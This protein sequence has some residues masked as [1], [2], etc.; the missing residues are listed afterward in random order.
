MEASRGFV[1]EVGDF[2]EEAGFEV[3]R[4]VK[5]KEAQ[6][7]ASRAMKDFV[8]NA[9]VD[10]SIQFG[11]NPAVEIKAVTYEELVGDVVYARRIEKG[12]RYMRKE[13]EK[14]LVERL[15]KEQRSA[16]SIPGF[17][18]VYDYP[19]KRLWDVE[20]LMAMTGEEDTD[21]LL[22]IVFGKVSAGQLKA[23]K[24]RFPD[25]KE[26]IEGAERIGE[27]NKKRLEIEETGLVLTE[28]DI[29]GSAAEAKP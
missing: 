7:E 15:S 17:E 10:M 24:D 4:N 19:E 16:L 25:L 22:R 8:E 9:P 5:I 21:T 20:E 14:R 12:G 2:L 13:A 28:A 3:K 1:E 26:I 29:E 23:L 27:G 6:M 11:D 18:I